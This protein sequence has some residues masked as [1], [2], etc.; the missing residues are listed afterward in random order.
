[1]NRQEYDKCVVGSENPKWCIF[2]SPSSSSPLPSSSST[3]FSLSLFLLF[4]IQLLLDGSKNRKNYRLESVFHIESV[5]FDLLR[6]LTAALYEVDR[7]H[8]TDDGQHRA[9]FCVSQ[10]TQ[11]TS[12]C[13]ISSMAHTKKEFFSDRIT[14]QEKMRMWNEKGIC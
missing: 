10:S 14:A 8:Q 11:Y 7:I 12:N 9:K 4:T 5:L 2:L 13:D 3:F 1:M 6:I